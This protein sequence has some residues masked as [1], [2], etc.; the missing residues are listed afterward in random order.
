MHKKRIRKIVNLITEGFESR[1]PNSTVELSLLTDTEL[2]LYYEISN[3]ENIW[4]SFVLKHNIQL[5]ELDEMDCES[6]II[7]AD[8]YLCE[9]FDMASKQIN[10][11]W[12]SYLNILS[13]DIQNKLSETYHN[14]NFKVTSVYDNDI[15]GIN[16][17]IVISNT[18]N[19]KTINLSVMDRRAIFTSRINLINK[20]VK[21][22]IDT[23]PTESPF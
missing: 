15:N 20:Y 3:R 11:G 18:F 14:V 17:N 13:Q 6:N 8:K 9:V 12:K 5:S 22:F 10:E 4:E 7:I 2:I 21:Q 16:I 1:Y 19:S 23:L